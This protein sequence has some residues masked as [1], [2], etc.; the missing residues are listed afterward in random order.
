MVIKNHVSKKLESGSNK[1]LRKM[2]VLPRA[3]S[4][5]RPPKA[6]GQHAPK[7]IIRVA[8]EENELL[9]TGEVASQLHI[10]ANTVR[11][12]GNNGVLKPYRLGTRADRRFSKSEVMKLLH[13][14]AITHRS[15]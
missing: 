8:P 4:L 1:A 11:R 10:H 14:R 12:W 5:R 7:A 13:K 9:T 2:R 3:A 6:P 15:V